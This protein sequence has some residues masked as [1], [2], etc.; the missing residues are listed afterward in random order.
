MPKSLFLKKG[1]K[2]DERNPEV[3]FSFGGDGTMLKAIH[4]YEDILENIKQR[5]QNLTDKLVKVIKKYDFIESF[6][7]SKNQKILRISFIFIFI[8]TS[9]NISKTK[10]FISVNFSFFLI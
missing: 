4:K 8:L 7:P 1:F 9:F 5:E 6:I 3:V 10:Y 2:L